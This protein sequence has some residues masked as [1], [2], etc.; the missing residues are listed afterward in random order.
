MITPAKITDTLTPR[1]TVHPL[2][3]HA[4]EWMARS[5]GGRAY[6]R[7]AASSRREA[8]AATLAMVQLGVELEKV[9]G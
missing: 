3:G 9:F 1:F 5:R 2:R 7:V 6:C 4:G 8:I